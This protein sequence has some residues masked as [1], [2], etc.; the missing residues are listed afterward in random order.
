MYSALFWYIR[1]I[2]K[3][4]SRSSTEE[5]SIHP[6]TTEVSSIFYLTISLFST[7]AEVTLLF[8]LLVDIGNVITF[9]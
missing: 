6:P 3:I 7:S 2:Q 1:R 9:H 8:V 5:L 4:K